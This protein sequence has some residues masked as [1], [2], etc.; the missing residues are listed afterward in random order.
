METIRYTREIPLRYRASVAVLGGGIA[1]VVAAITAAEAGADVVLV[2]RFGVLGGNA[3]SGGVANFCGDCTG[4]GRVFD[5]IIA[6]LEQFHAID[7]PREGGDRVFNHHIFAVVLQELALEAGVRLLLHCRLADAIVED[8]RIRQVILVG[9]SG[10]E[11]LAADVFLDCTGDGV[12]AR[13]AG[14]AQMKGD[15]WQL[16][17]SVMG[18]ARHVADPSKVIPVPA[19]FHRYDKREQMPMTTPWPDGPGS[20]ALKIK[21]PRF[22]A[23][24]TVQLT[25]AEI[26]AHRRLLAAVEYY[27][28][29]EHKNWNYDGASPIIGIREGARTVGDYVLTVEDLR[30]GRK[31]DTAVARGIYPLDGHKPDD[32]GRTYL[33]PESERD[34]PPYQIP[35]ECLVARDGKNMMMAGRCFSADQLALSSARVMTTCAMMGAAVGT[36]AA[37]CIQNNC[38]IRELDY[39]AVR[40]RLEAEG[41]VL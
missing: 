38:E 36:A 33:L 25:A 16:P 28:N 2:E 10:M 41:A 15:P 23:T 32:D 35:M 21:V 6:R 8:G 17:M 1:G 34:V 13:A 19:E 12:L 24:D 26:E 18:F 5:R 20:T 39:L 11:A 7:P 14:F 40:R 3:T 30:A 22:D 31:F 29:A 4:D 9:A 37:M 27:Q